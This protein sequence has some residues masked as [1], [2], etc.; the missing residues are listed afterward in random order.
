MQAE[1]SPPKLVSMQFESIS[2]EDA[3]SIKPRK[4]WQ[5]EFYARLTAYKF[6]NNISMDDRK[7]IFQRVCEKIPEMHDFNPHR[8]HAAKLEIFNPAKDSDMN[9]WEP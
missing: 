2:F 6:S 3:K 4:F 5:Y 7:L 8:I 1:A 9:N